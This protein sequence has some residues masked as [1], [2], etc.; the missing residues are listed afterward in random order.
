MLKIQ[1][2][3]GC[4]LFC[5]CE[6]Y[7]NKK[8][9]DV[10]KALTWLQLDQVSCKQWT[11]TVGEI[12][13]SLTLFL[14]KEHVRG[15]KNWFSKTQVETADWDYCA[16]MTVLFCSFTNGFQM[17]PMPEGVEPLAVTGSGLLSFSP[18]YR[19]CVSVRAPVEHGQLPSETVSHFTKCCHLVCAV[20]AA[21]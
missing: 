5:L 12:Q 6:T 7:G 21:Q 4:F 8:G 13:S 16:P 14:V 15:R 19:E 18:P 20:R 2:L 3:H 9:W 11:P 1:P 17:Q 10:F